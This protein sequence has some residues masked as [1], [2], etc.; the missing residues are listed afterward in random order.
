MG[1]ERKRRI[2]VIAPKSYPCDHSFLENVFAESFPRLGVEVFFVLNGRT[3]RLPWRKE[4]WK[5]NVVFIRP[6]FIRERGMG[7]WFQSVVARMN[8]LVIPLILWRVKPDFVFVRTEVFTCLAVIALSTLL[9]RK[10]RIFYHYN[11][12]LYEK[13]YQ[14]LLK[15]RGLRRL[16]K[17]TESFLQ[18]R[19]LNLVFR[20]AD[21]IYSI[22]PLMRQKLINEG[23]V[24]AGRISSLPLAASEVHDLEQ[25]RREWRNSIRKA[26]GLDDRFVA[27]YI[28][29]L[30]GIREA[31]LFLEIAAQAMAL[32]GDAFHLLIVGADMET[33]RAS[34][35]AEAFQRNLSKVV[36]VVTRIPRERVPQWLCAADVGLSP[37]PPT[38]YFEI[39]SP[40][41]IYEYMAVGC[42][43]VSSRIPEVLGI[44]KKAEAGLLSDHSAA[45]YALA[46]KTLYEN[47][48]LRD[49]CSREGLRFTKD[50]HNYKILSSTFLEQIAGR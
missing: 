26:C 35:T 31:S 18:R 41:K 13:E 1:T 27:I 16:F 8:V 12:P 43:F 23:R 21:R 24:E 46:L 48:S 33:Q 39:S 14:E 34:W 3:F 17:K 10:G 37:I 30:L 6:A 44:L 49:R 22:S 25:K 36:T 20:K 4:L 28:G 50:I 19:L 45:D 29:S 40:T 42:P 32:I 9:R 2:L 15:G 11:W 38:A 7:R 47:E 5:G